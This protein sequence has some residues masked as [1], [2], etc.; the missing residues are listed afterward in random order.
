[1]TLGHECEALN[2]MNNSML[3]MTRAAPGR[4]LND[5]DAMNGLRLGMIQTTRDP[6][7][8]IT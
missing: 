1:M 2:T 7:S 5:M 3:W 6:M 8:S 4:D